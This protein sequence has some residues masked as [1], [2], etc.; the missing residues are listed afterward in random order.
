MNKRYRVTLTA[1]ERAELVQ[2]L[3]RGKADVRK[4]R[5]A[6]MLMKADE[7]DAGPGWPDTRIAEALDVGVA[8][9]ERVRRRFVEEGLASALSPY[10]GGKRLY[11]RKLDGDAEAH[12]LA[13][14]CSSPPE[15]RSRWTLRLLARQ[16]VELAHVDRLSHEAVRQ[17]LKKE[18]PASA[19]PPH[20]VHSRQALGRVRSLHG[21][22]ARGLPP[23]L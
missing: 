10:R 11:T 14:A 8:T 19:P 17:T 18:R 6:Q 22:R 13:L 20:V 4:L 2:L 7:S 3:A 15:G 23:A 1:D 9:I 21:G 16:M 5:H 12:L